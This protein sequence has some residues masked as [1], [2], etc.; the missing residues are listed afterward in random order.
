MRTKELLKEWR[1]FLKESIKEIFS[2]DDIGIKVEYFPCCDDCKDFFV[3]KYGKAMESS[4]AGKL[5]AVNGN[6]IQL[7]DR[8]ENTVYVD[9]EMIPQCCVKKV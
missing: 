1:S 3:K 8:K 4:K 2:G 5:T 7:G 9:E 6:D